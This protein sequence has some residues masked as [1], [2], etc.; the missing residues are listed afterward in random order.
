[1]I[2]DLSIKNFAL[3]EDINISFG[4][5]LNVLTGE[6]GA[7]K[8]IIVGAT[9]LILGERAQTDL[10]RKGAKICEVSGIIRADQDNRYKKKIM[11]KGVEFEDDN[12]FLLKREVNMDGR[13]RCFVNRNIV[14]LSMLLEIGESLMDIHGQ[15]E[16]QMLLRQ[17][18]QREVLDNYGNLDKEVDAFQG[19]YQEYQSKK[20]KYDE[21]IASQAQR[22]QKIELYKYQIQEIKNARLKES[23]EG[24]L[25]KEL[26][27]LANAEKLY[28]LA[29]K[30]YGLLY[31][32]DNSVVGALGQIK[33]DIGAMV[34]IDPGIEKISKDMEDSIFRLEDIADQIR[35]YLDK[36]NF[37]PDRL[38][39]IQSRYE[40][41]NSLKRKYGLELKGILEYLKQI[42]EE[43]DS[44]K[45]IV[46]G[47]DD[48]GAELE[49]LEGNL[50]E[51]ANNL[52]KKRGEVARRLE[53]EVEKELKG[54]GFER[55]RFCIKCS[56]K[57]DKDGKPV[58]GTA[59]MDEIEFLIAPNIGEDLKPLKSCA[60]GGEMAR[61][62]LGLKTVLARSD[63]VS[64]LIF[65]EIDAGISG[66]MGTIVGEK[67]LK[68]SKNHQVI[69]ITHLSQIACFAHN[70]FKVDKKLEGRR[71]KTII[72]RLSDRER[73]DEIAR[74]LGGHRPTEI[75][76][77]HAKEL[78]N[79][80]VNKKQTAFERVS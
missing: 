55:I 72:K 45:I 34:K 13:N 51:R 36:I 35:V 66:G 56:K 61:I 27:I 2:E 71:T 12:T 11:D 59:G 60:S 15:H 74:M 46:E 76:L 31:E 75:T 68:L 30:A 29:G 77:K 42:E 53:R 63:E 39:E 38:E 67:L 37:E 4:K 8:S 52:S 24:E 80:G 14:T 57:L 54:L 62:M 33:R 73:I 43:L 10:I 18:V 49:K 7:G 17:V 9:G 3:I 23:E 32:S 44:L 50:R 41:I 47:K 79:R 28:G 69:C 70:H 6:T 65:D 26:R 16:H 48:L 1:M 40:F 22:Q 21:L 5:G 20:A 64:T 19:I 78:L 25:E 58:I